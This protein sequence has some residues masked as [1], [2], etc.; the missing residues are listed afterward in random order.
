MKIFRK[1]KENSSVK[2]EKRIRLISFVALA[3]SVAGLI[4][5]TSIRN[6]LF[7]EKPYFWQDILRFILLFGSLVAAMCAQDC[8]FWLE[9]E[10]RLNVF[11]LDA[12]G[13]LYRVFLNAE[14]LLYTP[15]FHAD[16]KQF[17]KLM[18]IYEKKKGRE[19]LRAA[20]E[21][22]QSEDFFI[23]LKDVLEEWE[24][25]PRS[26]QIQ[27]L[28]ELQIEQQSA[29]KTDISYWTAEGRTSYCIYQDYEGYEELIQLI[30]ERVAT[31]EANAS[32]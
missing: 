6:V 32:T 27:M 29:K 17:G 16:E 10:D 28:I 14:E 3:V 26:L 2:K 9:H 21:Y 1:G 15:Y 7:F 30:Q 19:R 22:F 12:K 24:I 31:Q 25:P 8:F 13:D 11:V 5:N 20:K 23:Y 18:F 4:Y